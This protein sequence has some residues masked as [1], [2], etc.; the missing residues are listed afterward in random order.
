MTP[1]QVAA[2][3]EALLH[4]DHATSFAW[5]TLAAQWARLGDPDAARDYLA[6]AR[7]I[8]TTCEELCDL[9]A[10]YDALGDPVAELVDAAI[11]AEHGA[12]WH[13]AA[14]HHLVL[15]DL[16]GA[17]AAI[18]RGWDHAT[19]FADLNALYLREPD[20]D[21]RD[22]RLPRLA[23]VATTAL[24]QLE[25]ARI[26]HRT[27]QPGFALEHLDRAAEL[28]TDARTRHLI[29]YR[30]GQWIQDAQSPAPMPRF[31]PTE[32]LEARGRGL[33][34]LA[35]DAEALLTRLRA[36][37]TNDGI[38]EI[39]SNDYGFSQ[40]A[41]DELAQIHATGTIAHPLWDPREECQLERWSSGATVNHTH[42]AFACALLCIDS[43]GSV[44]GDY[45]GGDLESAI[46]TLLESALAL[47]PDHV[48]DARALFVALADAWLEAGA[49]QLHFVDLGL[50]IALLAVD[51]HDPRAP[52]VAR[53]LLEEV[54]RE[55]SP[56]L[57]GLSN[58][59]QRYDV[60]RMLVRDTLSDVSD[61]D[62]AAVL[63]RLT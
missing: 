13:V 12:W 32:I 37:I 33:P 1:E 41:Y 38:A 47:G 5:R 53:R 40:Q 29:A 28:A 10:G 30:R 26:A 42:R 27:Y 54:P 3:G 58:F 56:W 34:G 51:R 60:F 14:L 21:E 61:R 25:L 59:D 22:Q 44:D 63:A 49:T 55:P 17:R 39:A 8:A 46:P 57:F 50:L 45:V 16:D 36:A 11:A 7:A 43:C 23:A 20:A 4:A 24:E 15:F 6:H 35:R 2:A 9:S 62:I 18:A 48:R 52:L 19:T 31:T